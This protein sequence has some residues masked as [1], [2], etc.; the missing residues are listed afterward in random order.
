[1]CVSLFAFG[2][3]PGN[4]RIQNIYVWY[5]LCGPAIRPPIRSNATTHGMKRTAEERLCWCVCTHSIVL[6]AH[7]LEFL[8]RLWLPFVVVLCCLLWL[9]L[10][11][12][13]THIRRYTV[14][15]WWAKRWIIRHKKNNLNS[16]LATHA[17]LLSP[18]KQNM[19][20]TRKITILTSVS[21]STLS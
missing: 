19:H 21:S 20:R 10:S 2:V 4:A 17:N 18:E 9:R 14:T 8:L 16:Y 15:I 5:T 3:A 6:I 7:T 13:N 1:M 12:T 11:E